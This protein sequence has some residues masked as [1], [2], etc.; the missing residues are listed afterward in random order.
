MAKR[1]VG[2]RYLWSGVPYEPWEVLRREGAKPSEGV[3][4]DLTANKGN[5]GLHD[6][7][8]SRK[9]SSVGRVEKQK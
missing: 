6:I 7:Y 4:K 8:S 5:I 1:A 3:A 9:L 2:I